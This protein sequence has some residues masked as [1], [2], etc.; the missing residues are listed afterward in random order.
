MNK[1]KSRSE[2]RSRVADMEGS[3]RIED[4]SVDL[5]QMEC[6]PPFDRTVSRRKSGSSHVR[7]VRTVA[8]LS[9]GGE[10]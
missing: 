6:T 3:M 2:G 7:S 1:H 4:R 8:V 10:T 5:L 9:R